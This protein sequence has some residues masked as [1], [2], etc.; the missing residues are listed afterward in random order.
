[1]IEVKIP[2]PSV[3]TLKEYIKNKGLSADDATDRYMTILAT[4]VYDSTGSYLRYGHEGLGKDGIMATINL[5]RLQA[6]SVTEKQFSHLGFS[7]AM[8]SRIAQAN[9]HYGND[10]PLANPES[11]NAHLSQWPTRWITIYLWLLLSVSRQVKDA[12]GNACLMED[13]Q[14]MATLMNELECFS[15]PTRKQAMDA[16]A[17][18]LGRSAIDQKHINSLVRSLMVQTEDLTCRSQ[19]LAFEERIG[20]QK[21]IQEDACAKFL[22]ILGGVMH[23]AKT[24]DEY[25]GADKA[26]KNN[27][28]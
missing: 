6:Y 14:L 21:R 24:D 27:S 2:S 20:E 12:K 18:S 15:G 4:S 22:R 3:A 10:C 25:F 26:L 1:M 13:K 11:L 9:K 28:I 17:Y 8:I 23:L 7:A 19:T 5:S 16:E